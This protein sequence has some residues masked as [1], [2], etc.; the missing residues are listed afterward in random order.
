VILG[1]MLAA[2]NQLS[3]ITAILEYAKQL[4]LTIEEGDK[5]EADISVMMLGFFQ[6]LITVT[7]GFFINRFGRRPMMLVGMGVLTV[8]LIIG[9]FVTQFIEEHERI[10]VLV[11][12]LHVLGYSVSLGPICMMYAVE[13]LEDISIVI[14]VNWGLYS[15]ITLAGDYLIESIGLPVLF[16]T[17]GV[18]S[19]FC[20]W[21]FY[22][23]MVETKNTT[24][25]KIWEN[26]EGIKI[27]W[28]KSFNIFSDITSK[29]KNGE[30]GENK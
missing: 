17:F 15:F 25:K 13:A 4:F 12:F 21:Y 18:S 23:Y 8:A 7:S 16:L 2:A 11:V 10:T 26:I 6:V 28:E 9:F 24:R 5:S 20:F 3:G 27:N 14:I 22:F 19:I 1:V 29:K 30:D